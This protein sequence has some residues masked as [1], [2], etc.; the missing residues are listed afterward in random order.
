MSKII[1]NLSS[2]YPGHISLTKQGK[3]YFAWRKQKPNFRTTNIYLWHFMT[4]P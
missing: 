4:Y 1:G 2:T 3:L